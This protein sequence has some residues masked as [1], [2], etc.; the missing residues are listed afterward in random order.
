MGGNTIEIERRETDLVMQALARIQPQTSKYWLLK[1]E[2]GEW[3][4]SDQASALGGVGPWDG[5]R[6][7]QAMN[8]L[9]AMRCGDQC[10]FYHS[11]AGAAS[12]RVVGVVEV[13]R[14]WYEGEEGEATAG[15]AVDVRAVGQFQRC[16]W[17]KEPSGPEQHGPLEQRRRD[18][19]HGGRGERA[20]GGGAP[21]RGPGRTAGGR[22]GVF[23]GGARRESGL[24]TAGAGAGA[25]RR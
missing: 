1:M 2:P 14:E 8:N 23:T 16:G 19:A 9:R 5:V 4:W 12:R 11:G 21:R 17:R 22:K 13:A 24:G 15:G 20:G 18:G 6:N 25:W 10:L 7:H 3:S